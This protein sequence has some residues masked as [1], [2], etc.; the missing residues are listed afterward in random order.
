MGSFGQHIID[1]FL[2]HHIIPSLSSSSKEIPIALTPNGSTTDIHPIFFM[3]DIDAFLTIYIGKYLSAGFEAAN[4]L[5]HFIDAHRKD[6]LFDD[7][8]LAHIRTLE[9]INQF[10]NC[11]L[12]VISDDEDKFFDRITLE[13]LC[14]TLY[15]HVCSITEYVE[16]AAE[17]L[18][19]TK[20]HIRII[21]GILIVM[22][23][24]GLR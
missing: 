2:I 1:F 10:A 14:T 4:N 22:I 15:Q 5:P 19:F 9:D 21:N 18:T 11:I 8:T 3:N 12:A 20:I 7:I 16:W 6:K 13:L 24:C 17:S 23:T